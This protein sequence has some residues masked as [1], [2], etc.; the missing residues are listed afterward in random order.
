[1]LR[2]CVSR[3]TV[4][5]PRNCTSD[6]GV[7]AH[8]EEAM[9]DTE[10]PAASNSEPV[11]IVRYPNRRLYDRSQARYVTLPEIAELVRKGKK[12]TV[13]DS[14]TGEDLTRLILTQIIVEQY[15]ERMELFP[16]SVLS[17]IIHANDTALG[18]LRDYLAQSLSY[19]ELM[20]RPATANP[21]LLPLQWMRSFVPNPEMP[22]VTLGREPD[23]D[24][25]LRRIAELERRL[26]AFQ[27]G[28]A[29]PATTMPARE[30][31][32]RK[33]SASR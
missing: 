16:V 12:V 4:T 23:S 10:A 30:K 31:P 14:K 32:G 9:A 20:Q 19:L 8:E 27:A 22:H 18:F 3:A 29:T 28:E 1:M 5:N 6:L 26:D 15:P 2:L 33:R 11:P 13:R 21:L 24:A 17:S 7:S 25:L